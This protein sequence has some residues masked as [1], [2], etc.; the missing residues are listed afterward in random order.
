MVKMNKI[1][2]GYPAENQL[3]KKVHEKNNIYN[4]LGASQQHLPADW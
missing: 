1:Y 2:V 4:S 3:K